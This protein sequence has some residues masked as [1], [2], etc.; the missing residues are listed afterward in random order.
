MKRA[1]FLLALAAVPAAAQDQALLEWMDKIAQRQLAARAESIASIKTTA[2]AEKRKQWVYS[3]LLELLG[4]LP[5][6]KG[7]LNARVVGRVDRGAY[8][9]ER[10]LF[11]SL[12]GLYVTGNLYRPSTGKHPGILMPLGHW[13]N[14]KPAV[15]RF[16]TNLALK[17]FVVFTYDPLGQ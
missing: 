2:D 9:I 10:V 8:V 4:G 1:L 11:E 14:G 7:S 12:P 6:Y 17:G 13:E 3:K 16:A 5:D 15:Q